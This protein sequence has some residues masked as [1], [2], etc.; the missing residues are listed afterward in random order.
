LRGA[1]TVCKPFSEPFVKPRER[2]GNKNGFSHSQPLAN[3]N[4]WSLNPYSSRHQDATSYFTWMLQARCYNFD[5]YN[6]STCA[7]M[8]EILPRCLDSIRLAEQD[9]IW[10]VEKRVASLDLCWQL[11]LGDTHGTAIEDVRK[12]ASAS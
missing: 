11:V 7:E 12:K 6:S 5:M 4:D 1:Q 2:N 8:F 3:G 9:P 10:S